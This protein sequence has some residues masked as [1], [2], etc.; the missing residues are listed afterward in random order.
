MVQSQRAPTGCCWG[1]WFSNQVHH[2]AGLKINNNNCETGP[3]DAAYVYLLRWW[4]AWS[5]HTA[6]HLSRVGGEFLFASCYKPDDTKALFA[7][8]GGFAITLLCV[9]VVLNL[10]HD[11]AVRASLSET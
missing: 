3:K 7:D 10:I 11:C 5:P 2:G 9:F 4:K 1:C 6:E 8:V